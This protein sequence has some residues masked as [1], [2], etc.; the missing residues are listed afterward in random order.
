VSSL[1]ASGLVLVTAASLFWIPTAFAQEAGETRS[2]T[3]GA[4]TTGPAPTEP[5][6]TGST[7]TV[8]ADPW[9]ET[10]ETRHLLRRAS[11]FRQKARRLHRLMG[12]PRPRIVQR[13]RAEFDS[14]LA[15]R[16][17]LRQAWRGRA[18]RAQL[19]SRRPPHLRAWLCIH[20]L[21]GHWRDAN[22]P[23]YGGLQMDLM[24]QR[25]YGSD[26]LRSKGTADHWTPYEQMWV[27]E[28]ALR[29]SGGFYPWPLTARRCGLI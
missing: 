29:S 26:L 17:W 5:T 8:M 14:L 3:T 1:R 11:R 7:E 22:A 4:T 15:Y 6:Q 25:Q 2:G 18:I 9:A 19:R 16:Q 23:Y 12:I 24:F 27:A 28:R 13:D 20:R 21:E 10:F